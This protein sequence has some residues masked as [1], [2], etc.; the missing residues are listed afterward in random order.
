MSKQ[1]SNYFNK[2]KGRYLKSTKEEKTKILDEYVSNSGSNRKYL[3]RLLNKK[4]SEETPKKPGRKIKYGDSKLLLILKRIWRLT[5]LPCSKKLKVIIPLWLPSYEKHYGEVTKYVKILLK[6]ISDRTIDRLFK[7]IRDRYRKRGLCSTKP[8]TWIKN[9]IPIKTNQWDENKP[10][11][12]EADTV[13]HCDN[14]LQGSFVYTV[15]VVDIKT[16]WTIQR[17]VWGK[18]STGVLNALKNI[19]KALPFKVLGFDCDNMAQNF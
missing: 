6:S 3:I 13:A 7:G 18:G 8:G 11:F 5:N 15:N 10:G 4:H 12:L 17:A 9:R 2:L 16:Q 14:S 1:T 19:E